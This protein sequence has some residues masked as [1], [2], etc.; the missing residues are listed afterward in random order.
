MMEVKSVYVQVD[1]S[2]V[3][4]LKTIAYILSLKSANPLNDMKGY[5]YNVG[6]ELATET[7]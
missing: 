5:R 7:T 1:S 3:R 2:V 4:T 6:T